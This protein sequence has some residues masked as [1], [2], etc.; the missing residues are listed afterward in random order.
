MAFARTVKGVATPAI[1]FLMTLGLSACQQQETAQQQQ[2]PQ[3][4]PVKVLNLAT[5]NV[6]EWDEF[7]GRFQAAKRVEVKARVSGFIESVTFNDG[8]LIEK[9]QVLYELDKRPF[10]IALDS[11]EAQ[12]KL[13]QKE[14]DRGQNLVKNNSISQEQL[15]ERLQQLQVAQANYDQASLNLEFASVTAPIT[16]RIDRTYVN[17][18]NLVVGGN[19]SGEP[20]TTIVTTNPIHFYFS[21]SETTVLNYIRRQIAHPDAIKREDAWP[22]FVKLQDEDSFAHDG[23]M[24][25]TSNSLDFATGTIEVRA[26]FDNPD[27]LLQPGMFGRLRLSP[28]PPYDAIT[29]EDKWIMS[30]QNKK[31]VYIVNGENKAEK[32]YVTLGGTTEAGL[33]IIKQGLNPGEQLVIGNL[34]MIQ[35]GALLQ[36]VPANT[37]A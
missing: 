31:Y 26:V 35:P 2:A 1:L 10:Q 29:I 18:G 27:N 17:E 5:E 28:L 24:D 37:G 11:A 14:L 4:M 19:A 3:A 6:T 16:G 7:T 25:F 30:E 21:A 13:A 34:Q 20:L 8:Q 33:R 22:V 9:G 36:P 23:T 15:D 32:R 12:L